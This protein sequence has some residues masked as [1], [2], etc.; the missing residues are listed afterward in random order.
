M[1]LSEEAAAAEAGSTGIN[2][3]LPIPASSVVLRIHLIAGELNCIVAGNL[4]LG[5]PVEMHGYAM[6]MV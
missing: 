6:A 1:I 4:R 5:A 3:V 2:A